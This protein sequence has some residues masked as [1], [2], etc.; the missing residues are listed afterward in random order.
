VC[1]HLQLKC[2]RPLQRSAFGGRWRSPFA[3]HGPSAY[4]F[5]TFAKPK[6]LT[7]DVDIPVRSPRTGVSTDPGVRGLSF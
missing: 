5:V 3:E 2:R 6:K 7:L 4:T 1:R